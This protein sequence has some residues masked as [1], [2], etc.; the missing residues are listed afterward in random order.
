MDTYSTDDKQNEKDFPGYPH[1]PAGEDI[2]RAA[3]NNGKLPID[4]A[5]PT[6]S[7]AEMRDDRDAE[8]QIPTG[9][10]ADV[11]PEEIAL[12]DYAGNNIDNS[13][14]TRG[15][16]DDT[17]ADGDRLQEE[18]SL[19]TATSGSSL[20]VPGADAD[21]A[22]ESIGEEDEENNYYSLGGDKD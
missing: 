9:S 8:S 11:T 17:D 12:L 3:N 20:D 5:Q 15:S 1:Y 18:S 7:N 10:D 4:P 16:L 22:N 21:D 2:T 19:Y 13:D 6:D 14:V